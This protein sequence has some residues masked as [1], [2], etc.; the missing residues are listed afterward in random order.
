[1]EGTDP[2]GHKTLQE[3]FSALCDSALDPSV[4]ARHLFTKGIINN[5]AREAAK[6][7]LT[8]KDQRLDDL[9][10]LVMADGTPGAFQMFVE[11]V[12]KHGAVDW[13]VEK[14]KGV[15]VIIKPRCT[16]AA[17]AF[18][19]RF[20]CVCVSVCLSV[21]VFVTRISALPLHFG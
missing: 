9:L 8:P 21:C 19:S 17:R 5:T 6:Q 20:V 4:L 16:C 7:Q 1:M 10:G 2:A 3:H 18:C 14:L 11:A 13:L 12:E 15:F